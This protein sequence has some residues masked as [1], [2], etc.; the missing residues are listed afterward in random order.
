MRIRPNY[1]QKLELSDS[2]SKLGVCVGGE[3]EDAT[4]I[5]DNKAAETDP[6]TSWEDRWVFFLLL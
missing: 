4:D 3:D 6:C 5:D 1:R 2:S